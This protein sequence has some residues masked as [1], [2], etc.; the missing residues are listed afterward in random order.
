[1]HVDVAVAIAP[2][3]SRYRVGEQRMPDLGADEG[4]DLEPV[5]MLEHHHGTPRDL[6]PSRG[7]PDSLEL[8]RR[9]LERPAEVPRGG[10]A[11]RR[12]LGAG[13]AGHRLRR[14]APGDRE[15]TGLGEELMEAEDRAV[16][17][18]P[19]E[20]LGGPS[21][22]GVGDVHPGGQAHLHVRSERIAEACRPERDRV[23]VEPSPEAGDGGDDD[24]HSLTQGLL[25][26]PGER[27]GDRA[28]RGKRRL[29]RWLGEHLD[30]LAGGEPAHPRR[31]GQP[32][33]GARRRA[34][35]HTACP[36]SAARDHTDVHRRAGV[37]ESQ[38]LRPVLRDAARRFVPAVSKRPRPGSRRGSRA[39]GHEGA[40]SA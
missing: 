33:P 2:A 27:E 28:V 24:R 16:S 19:G 35:G 31:R 4:V 40:R 30:A 9:A 10:S 22:G 7:P 32:L 5:V 34:D 21:P 11:H 13:G 12:E 6:A 15:V 37:C 20:R 36:L 25:L 1:M 8:V 23:A 17:H 14:G 39:S 26:R 3:L 29:G 38:R 18:L